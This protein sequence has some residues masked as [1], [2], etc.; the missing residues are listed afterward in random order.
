MLLH[1][2]HSSKTININNCDV[3]VYHLPEYSN[4]ALPEGSKHEFANSALPR[5]SLQECIESKQ[6]PPKCWI[7]VY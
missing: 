2:G 3:L 6:K 4:S 7:I 1:H 5:L